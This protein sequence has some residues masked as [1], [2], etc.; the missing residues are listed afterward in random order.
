M[1]RRA[2]L[3]TFRKCR[4][5]KLFQTVNLC[6]PWVLAKTKSRSA[7]EVRVKQWTRLGLLLVAL[8]S[9][10]YIVHCF[11][12]DETIAYKYFWL[13]ALCI[14]V[15]TSVGRTVAEEYPIL[16]LG[17]RIATYTAISY[18][19]PFLPNRDN[20]FACVLQRTFSQ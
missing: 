8:V 19:A 11:R 14:Y 4:V 2:T 20:I 5:Q 10:G 7:R 18:H 15:R 3:V 13:T 9:C 16:A 17:D 12:R 6:G 1:L